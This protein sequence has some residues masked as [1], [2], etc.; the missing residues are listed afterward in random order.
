VVIR[1]YPL[2]QNGGVGSFRKRSGIEVGLLDTAVLQRGLAV[3]R[4]YHGEAIRA[5]CQR[6]KASA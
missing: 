1:S 2:L 5:A 4:E 3:V 6:M